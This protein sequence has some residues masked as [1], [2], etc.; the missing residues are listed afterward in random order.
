VTFF[1]AGVPKPLGEKR[2]FDAMFRDLRDAGI[3]VFMPFSEYQELPEPKS[4]EYETEFFP[5]YSRNSDAIDSLKRHRMKL[6]VPAAVL[7]PD[8]KIPPLAEDPLKQMIAWV[9]RDNIFAIYSYDEPALQNLTNHSKA[10]YERVKQVDPTMPVMIVQSAIP[11]SATTRADFDRYLGAVK[12]S[13]QYADIVGFDVYAIPRDLMKVQGPFSGPGKIL[14]YKQAFAEYIHW[15]KANLPQKRHLMVLQAFS[16]EDQGHSAI[17]A[18]QYRDRRPTKAEMLDMLQITAGSNVSVGW[19]G[20]SLVKDKDL[21]F[22][23][24]LLD[25]TKQVFKQTAK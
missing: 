11:E 1:A 9:G 16:C 17:L 7:Y 19:W 25:V 21:K 23:K 5:Q 22:W 13:S 12:T 10:L 4:L 8:G 6:L 20:Q 3:T 2:N 15:L 18:K 14:D 24:D